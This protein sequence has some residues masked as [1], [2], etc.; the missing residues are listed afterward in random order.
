MARDDRAR[1]ALLEALFDRATVAMWLVDRRTGRIVDVND[2]AV[3]HHGLTREALCARSFDDLRVALTVRRTEVSHELWLIAADAPPATD[4]MFRALVEHGSTGVALYRSDGTTVYVNPAVTDVLGIPREEMLAKSGTM[5]AHPDDVAQIRGDFEALQ[6]TP[7]EKRTFEIRSQ[8][9]DGTWRWVES[10][11]TNLLHEPDV[12]GIVSNFR[13]VTDRKT[14]E[15]ARA[16]AQEALRRSEANFRALAEQLPVGILVHRDGRVLYVNP[17]GV[18]LLGYDTAD[19]LIGRPALELA[20]PDV[21]ENVQTRMERT[22]QLGRSPPYETRMLRRDGSDVVVEMEGILL[23]YDGAPSNV[24]IAH[25]VTERREM[26]TRLALADRMLSVGTLAAGV[27]HEINNPLA[28]VV[29]NLELLDDG[30]PSLLGLTSAPT[31]GGRLRPQDVADLLKDARDG[32]SRMRAVVNDLRALSRADDARREPVD[33]RAVIESSVKLATNE[34]RHRARLVL[35]L[36]DV[37]RVMGNESRLGQVVLNVLLNAAQSIPDGHANE[38]EIRVRLRPPIDP[39]GM[40]SIEITDTGAGIPPAIQRRIFDPFFTTKPIGVGTGLGLSICHGIVRSL[41]GDIT[42]ESTV[43]TGTTFQIVFPIAKELPATTRLEPAPTP[44]RRGNILVIDDEP[45][46][47]K[48]LAFLLGRDHE[49]AFV[50][51]G[52]DALARLEGGEHFDVVLCDLMMPE[53]SGMEFHARLA[54]RMPRVA[55]RVVFLT[56]GAFTAKARAF[57]EG[58]SA[59]TLQKPFEVADLRATIASVLGSTDT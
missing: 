52:A 7:G 19:D 36:T 46:I 31:V 6:R 42:F 47:G 55:E 2:V 39:T 16:E 38:N 35:D 50:T 23:T 26:A 44:T 53:M 17:A 43:G 49:V 14:A 5:R 57:L 33:L 15:L 32:A 54:E 40:V 25:D 45:A 1:D 20:H 29:A 48:S 24:V 4:K 59:R 30:L 27:A 58:V 9:R 18:A 34:I 41:G 22:K 13:D 8:H 12:R 28:Y 51:R 10:V 3:E 37:P 11:V 56:G 21:R